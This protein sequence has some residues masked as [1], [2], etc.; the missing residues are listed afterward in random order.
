MVFIL[1]ILTSTALVMLLLYCSHHTSPPQKESASERCIDNIHAPPPWDRNIPKGQIPQGEQARNY[2]ITKQNYE[3]QKQHCTALHR[4]NNCVMNKNKTYYVPSNLYE[5]PV[6]FETELTNVNTTQYYYAYHLRQN[7]F[8]GQQKKLAEQWV[9]KPCNYSNCSDTGKKNVEYH[10]REVQ[11]R[12]WLQ[13][14]GSYGTSRTSNEI[15]AAID[16]VSLLEENYKKA[17]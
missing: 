14:S 7:P 3:L 4:L 13:D 10:I 2:K 11:G 16:S 15:I 17:K 9:K 5:I 12:S 6:T 8:S 1:F